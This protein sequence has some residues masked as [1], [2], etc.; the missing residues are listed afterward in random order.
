[1]WVG[2][3]VRWAIDVHQGRHGDR[4]RDEGPRGVEV[5]QDLHVLPETFV[6]DVL[7]VA[8]V[9]VP[10]AAD[11]DEP[12]DHMTTVVEL[13]R[14]QEDVEAKANRGLLRRS[15]PVAEVAYEKVC[16]DPN[17]AARHV[18]CPCFRV[19]SGV[20]RRVRPKEVD[21][22]LTPAAWRA[23][24]G[25]RCRSIP[26]PPSALLDSPYHQDISENHALSEGIKRWDQGPLMLRFGLPEWSP[27]SRLDS[28]RNAFAYLW[29]S[30]YGHGSWNSNP[31][32]WA[33]R[34]TRLERYRA[35]A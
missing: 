2:G 11:H 27:T 21:G 1:V 34:F 8:A 20:A 26:P 25:V 23:I 31:W 10:I 16:V 15:G 9:A 14:P 24:P 19:A 5:I 17:E 13:G 18:D 30:I 4:P 6:P 28:A 29:E 33:Y 12:Q 35:A 22:E 32:V 3:K 7:R